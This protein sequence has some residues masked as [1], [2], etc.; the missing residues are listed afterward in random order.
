[1][2][3]GGRN[4][5]S[6][7]VYRCAG[8][9]VCVCMCI[10][11]LSPVLSNER[12]VGFPGTFGFHPSPPQWLLRHWLYGIWTTKDLSHGVTASAFGCSK[13]HRRPWSGRSLGPKFQDEVQTSQFPLTY[14]SLMPVCTQ[15]PASLGL[16]CPS[17]QQARFSFSYRLQTGGC[18]WNLAMATPLK[19]GPCSPA[20]QFPLL[21]IQLHYNYN[22]DKYQWCFSIKPV[23]L[24]S[25]S[26]IR[27]NMKQFLY[28]SLYQKLGNGRSMDK[29]ACFMKSVRVYFF[30]EVVNIPFCLICK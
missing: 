5:S 7:C 19:Q 1:M 27:R 11:W 4:G 25:H 21:P 22:A 8:L 24:F 13:L 16:F 2:V 26:R 20:P 23:L 6:S 14:K 30:V 9:H 29:V 17:K 18:R 15:T 12:R 3:G 10:L 28:L